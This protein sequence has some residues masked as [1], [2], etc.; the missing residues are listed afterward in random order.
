M[1]D[2]GL[3]AEAA[4]LLLGEDLCDEA[5]VPQGGEAAV[6]GDGDPRRLLAAVLER[7]EAEVREPGDVALGGVDADDAAHQAVPP[8]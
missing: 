5:H 8:S 4:E 2:R 6:V 7:E 1:A 3:P